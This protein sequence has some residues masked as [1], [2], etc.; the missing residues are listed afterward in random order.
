ML[1]GALPLAPA[2]TFAI[3]S[4]Y[5]ES[6]YPAVLRIEA[7]EGGFRAYTASPDFEKALRGALDLRK[8]HGWRPDDP[9]PAYVYPVI[10]YSKQNGFSRES[11][12]T[13]H[14]EARCK[15]TAPSSPSC[16]T[17]LPPRERLVKDALHAEASLIKQPLDHTI[18]V[19]PRA[20]D[21]DQDYGACA[22][23]DGTTWF[24]IS[25]YEGEGST[26]IGGIG[27]HDPKTGKTEIRRPEILRRSS[28]TQLLYDGE[29][30]WLGTAGNYECAGTP[31][32]L[33][34]VRYHWKTGRILTFLG[35][36]GGPCGLLVNGFVQLGDDLWVATDL[37]LS[38]WN[39]K[40]SKWKN[41][42]PD[43]SASPPM[44]ET[45]CPD[46]YRQLTDTLPRSGWNE[47]M[48]ASS[49]YHQL[50]ETLARLR[51]RGIDAATLADGLFQVFFPYGT[52]RNPEPGQRAYDSEDFAGAFQEIKQRAEEGDF[53]A[54]YNLGALY[55]LG[56]GVDRDFAQ[57]T[58]W[59]GK[60]AARGHAQAQAN[61]GLLL[62][63][64]ARTKAQWREAKRWLH[65]ASDQDSNY[66]KTA[67]LLMQHSRALESLSD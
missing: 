51:P 35:G 2:T 44:R 6:P 7:A 23:R 42:V 17:G 43:P 59:L 39:R 47:V 54:Q 57:A 64:G 27:R 67:L 29:Y 25:Y 31:P 60:A 40:T 26:G 32:T 49:P 62:L 11:P 20:N 8:Q 66:A 65:K 58:T 30:L 46:L 53:Q 22:L 18:S 38:S 3:S 41:Y 28:I 9:G 56:K 16:A 55:A 48:P 34:L 37:G 33:G 12:L 36:N 61:L 10:G 52:A 13:C 19:V 50:T 4:C 45:S 1:L 63:N 21:I 5:D 15:E 24:G 14:I